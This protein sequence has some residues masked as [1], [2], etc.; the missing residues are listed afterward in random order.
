MEGRTAQI[1][2]CQYIFRLYRPQHI[3][4]S[5]HILCNSYFLYRFDILLTV[6]E[7]DNF[8]KQSPFLYQTSHLL[9]CVFIHRQYFTS[10]SSIF[11]I[12]AP[13]WD[14]TQIPIVMIMR[15]WSI[16]IHAPLWDATLGIKDTAICSNDFNPRA[17]VGRD[18]K[19]V[20]K[21][22]RINKN[23]NPRAPVGRDLQKFIGAL[24]SEYVFQSTRPC[25]T[26]PGSCCS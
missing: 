17:P 5:I 3:F 11:Q 26:R 6:N 20:D 15:G 18:N 25:G 23:F 22:N 9:P 16:S 1:I 2:T 10:Y 8:D 4:V 7:T 21:C 12:H 19:I 14:A 24:K 13:L